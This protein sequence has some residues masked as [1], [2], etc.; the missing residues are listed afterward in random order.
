MVSSHFLVLTFTKDMKTF[1]PLKTNNN[2]SKG[3]KSGEEMT[4][5][6][7]NNLSSR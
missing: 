1:C 6:L 5:L 7:G 3:A 4:S 2:Q